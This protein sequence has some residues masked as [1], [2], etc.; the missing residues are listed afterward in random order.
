MNS[1]T[2]VSNK[3]IRL[4]IIKNIFHKYLL[5]II[6][7]VKHVTGINGIIILK[8]LIHKLRMEMTTKK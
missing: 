4:K 3:V 5:C 8:K 7:R 2:S 1:E 6:G